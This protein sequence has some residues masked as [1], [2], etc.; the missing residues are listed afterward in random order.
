MSTNSERILGPLGAQGVAPRLLFDCAATR[1]LE[2][3]AAATLPEHA[4]MERAGL[5]LARLVLAVAPHARTIWIA[6]GPGNNGG[7]GL[8]AAWH[9]KQWGKEPVVT[10]LASAGPPPPDALAA[11][12]K[13]L[14]AQVSFAEQVPQAYDVCI[15][16]LFGIGT[17]RPFDSTCSALIAKINAGTA[18]VISADLPSGLDADTGASGTVYVRAD[19]TL[20]LLTL[21]PGLFTGNGRDA[22]GEIWF[23]SLGVPQ[24]SGACAQL[25]PQP[26]A[27]VRAH[28]THKGTYGDVGIVGGA[29][30]MAGAA[31]LAATAA[32]RGGAGRT[33]LTLLDSSP[34]HVDPNQ[35]E[36]MFRALG[37]LSV[38]TMTVVA[39]CGGGA[40]ILEHLEALITHAERLV[41]DA[42][43]LNGLATRPD[44]VRLVASRRPQSTV[45]TP[46]PL[47]AARL[48]GLGAAQV[49][50]HRLGAAQAL[51]D[52][53]A[54]TVVLKGSGTVIAAPRTRAAINTTGNAR[55]AT[56]GT[57]DVLAGLIGARMANGTDS[58]TAACE[59]AFRHGQVA[60]RWDAS[61]NLS[62]LALARAL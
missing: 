56:A 60:D 21:K 36:L 7:D 46:H 16:A 52:R 10:C 48:L 15:D 17:V 24:P 55:L 43:A 13:A 34:L 40:R 26:T 19:Y 61:S 2:A 3:S 58:F 45:L 31:L 8:E 50:A 39:G 37:D 23:D 44:L 25:N 32:L 35:P 22:C 5:A 51:A 6:C 11:R 14:Q 38:R 1:A 9:L 42:D 28:N 53:F 27:L 49:Q 18:P 59:A 29:Q 20:C 4:L 57:G 41:L 33:Y 47:E 12:H 62:A 30:G 54:C